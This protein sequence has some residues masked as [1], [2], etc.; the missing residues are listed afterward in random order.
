MKNYK[1][2]VPLAL[3]ALLLL[4]VYML[5]DSRSTTREEYQ[6]ALAAAR[7]YRERGITVD[8]EANYR[9]AYEL[10]P[11][12]ELA[13][14]LAGMYK[15]YKMRQPMR[16]WS[17][18]M[19]ETYPENVGVYEMMVEYYRDL[20]D[21]SN[22]YTL[23][24]EVHAR[25]IPSAKIDAIEKELTYVFDLGN[26]F[27]GVSGFSNGLAAIMYDGKW[28]YVNE[29]GGTAAYRNYSKAGAF[30][31]SGLAPVVDLEGSAYFIDGE[32][33]RKQVVEGVEHVVELGFISGNVFPL[34][35]GQVWAYYDLDGNKLFG[36]YENALAL[37]NGV[38]AVQI[39][40]HWSLI[41]NEGKVISKTAYDRI[42]ADEKTVVCRNERIFVE[43]GIGVHMIDPNGSTYGD[44]YEDAL[45]FNDNTY[46]AVEK[47]GKWGFVDTSGKMVLKNEYDGARSFSNGLAAV[48]VDNLWGYID[49][50][51]N[52]VIEPQF[53]EA[54]DFTASG[55]TFIRIR[56]YWQL[57]T[58]YSHKKDD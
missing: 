26:S 46:A 33:N 12:A 31:S 9:A 27:D 49:L 30:S 7:S 39:D 51:G 48:K 17:A 20:G 55:T 41:N 2:I 40:G 29:T 22:C 19:L 25:Q 50:E 44:I 43:D 37:A 58:F 18:T 34:Y 14:E 53:V 28:G 13:V 16:S 32:G 47:D 21:Y 52:M 56:N 24:R 35:N 6:T 42:I 3:V 23:I 5:Y 4:S 38:A 57:L 54:K 15:E 36:D 11:S 1:L 45:L 8:A 10:Q